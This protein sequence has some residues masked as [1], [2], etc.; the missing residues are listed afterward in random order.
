MSQRNICNTAL[1]VGENGTPV[2]GATSMFRKHARKLVKVWT[3][4][5]SSQ[6]SL[7]IYQ[8]MS[9]TQQKAITQVL[10]KVYTEALESQESKSAKAKKEA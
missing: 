9:G 3:G 7:Q 8:K 2:T 10:T 1:K 5:H 6:Q 4:Q